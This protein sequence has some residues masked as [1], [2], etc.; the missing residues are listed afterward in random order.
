MLKVNQ[1][2]KATFRK[3]NKVTC[4]FYPGTPFKVVAKQWGM[5]GE[6]TYTIQSQPK[7]IE[8]YSGVKEK[9]L[10]KA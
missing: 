3:G 5:F 8:L 9:F 4:D 1:P 10:N 7:G 6:L 2:Q